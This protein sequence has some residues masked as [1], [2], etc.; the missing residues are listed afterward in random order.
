[1]RSKT[2]SASTRRARCSSTRC[3]RTRPAPA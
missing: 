1:M 2:P 3:C